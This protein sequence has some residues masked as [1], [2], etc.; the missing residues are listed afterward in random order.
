MV[1]SGGS[2]VKVGKVGLTV[3]ACSPLLT[4]IAGLEVWVAACSPLL[5]WVW[6]LSMVGWLG[7]SSKPQRL[8]K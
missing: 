7:G 8:G 1:Q 3:T 5:L 6:I 4:P 2:C